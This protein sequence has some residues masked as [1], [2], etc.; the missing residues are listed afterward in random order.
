MHAHD[1]TID[2]LHPAVVRLDDGIH[3]LVPDA[4]FPPAVEAIV[5]GRIRPISLGQIAPRCARAQNP[6]DAVENLAVVL[7]LRPTPIQ[8]QQRF[9]NAPLKV[10]QIVSHEAGSGV[11]KLESLFE[12]PG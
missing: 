2:H 5:S 11:S 3:Q 6:E 4:C 9:D 1:R 12:L 8:R 7:R 10:G